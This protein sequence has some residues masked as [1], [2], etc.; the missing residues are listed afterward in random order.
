M[1]HLENKNPRS[2]ATGE[3]SQKDTYTGKFTLPN[4]P[5]QARGMTFE[6]AFRAA[7]ARPL[8]LPVAG[9]HHQAPTQINWVLP[10]SR[11]AV[12]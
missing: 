11:M 9:H 12:A 5:N 10:G 8:S 7:L 6:Q 1:G 2:A 4:R 3:G